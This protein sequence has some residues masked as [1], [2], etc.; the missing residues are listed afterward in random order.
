MRQYDVVKG[1]SRRFAIKHGAHKVNVTGV[2]RCTLITRTPQ[3]VV[4]RTGSYR[5]SAVPTVTS[6]NSGAL[7]LGSST[8]IMW[9]MSSAVSSGYF[10]LALTSTANGSSTQLN[11]SAIA[12]NRRTTSY[13]A[14]W[15]VAQAAGNYRVWVYY[16]SSSGGV[17]S[18]AGSSGVVSISAA[19]APTP[20]PTVT[21]TGTPTPTPKPT[22]TPTVTPTPTPTPTVTPTVTPTPTPTVNP[23]DA[24]QA[25]KAGDTIVVGA[26]TFTGNVRVPDGVTITGAGAT[27]SWLKGKLTF[28]SNDVI[29]DVEIGDVG[30]SAVHNRDGATNTLFQRVH[31]RGGS[32]PAYTYVVDLGSQATCSHIT[33]KD[34]EIERNLGVETGTWGSQGYNDICVWSAAGH[35][36]SDI[37][38][39]GVHVG[40]SN[41]AGGHDTG[42]PR[43]DIECYTEGVAG[44]HGWKNITLNNCVLEAADM[45]TA[46]FADY[47]G[48]RASGVLIQG[49]TFVGGGYAASYFSNTLNFEMPLGVVVRNNVFERGLGSWGYILNVTDDGTKGGSGPGAIFTGNTFDLDTD[50]GIAPVTGGWP[51]VLMGYDNQ[52]TN[53]TVKCHYG[54]QAVLLLNAAQRNIV[55]GNTFTVG[56]RPTIGTINGAT[57]NTTSPNTVN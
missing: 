2:G 39:D 17:L 21:P 27:V 44:T 24:I 13:T 36:V 35:P 46:D 15:K 34:S 7:V 22:V 31:L 1:H 56:S 3:V 33:F 10:R 45:E 9:K 26:G 38:F 51:I 54:S 53:N 11:S 20:T 29:Q 25:A 8:T 32:G 19:P 14:S 16:C 52:F 12:T 42:S 30:M 28:G 55:T 50:D 4:L 43:F 49:C 18:S 57:G 40:V 6:P 48:A 47:A 5:S 41:G 37:T 23:I